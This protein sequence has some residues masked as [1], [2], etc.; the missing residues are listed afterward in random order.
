[1]PPE[2]APFAPRL[3]DETMLYERVEDFDLDEWKLSLESSR[4]VNTKPT[5]ETL[6]D[7]LPP[8]GSLPKAGI[9]ERLRDKGVSE[10]KSRVFIS[11]VLAPS[12][13]VHGWY[14]KRS[15]RRE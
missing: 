11:T 14:I 10:K 7:L 4:D 12:G 1:M 6:L 9:I 2:S 15:G 8:N 3:D 13:P 5:T